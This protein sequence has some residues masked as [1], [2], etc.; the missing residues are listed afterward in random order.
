MSKI[1]CDTVHCILAQEVETIDETGVPV[2]KKEK[3]WIKIKSYEKPVYRSTIK[4]S[5]AGPT[6]EE[7]VSVK[8]RH[9]DIIK[10]IIEY[11]GFHFLLK[12]TSDEHVFY[13][14]TLEYPASIELSSNK[15]FDDI[16][17]RALSPA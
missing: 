9:I 15:I 1:I 5:D 11:C 3:E 13:V 10:P 8:I 17:F 4:T 2:L 6:N 14:G 7:T 16:T 12:L